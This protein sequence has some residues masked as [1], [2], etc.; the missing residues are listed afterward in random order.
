[1]SKKKI[2]TVLAFFLSATIL[3][4]IILALLIAY[5]SMDLPKISS[6]ADYR[7]V[8]PSQILAKDGTVLAELGKEKREVVAFK[9][10]PP[11]IVDAFLSAEDSGFYQHSGIDFEGILRAAIKNVVA[12]KV[13]QGGST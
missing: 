13:V 12:G 9:D 7:P 6:L 11:I 3:G 1:M 10:I 8:I 5:F 2:I 4:T